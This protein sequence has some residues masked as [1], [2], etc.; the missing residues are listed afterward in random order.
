MEFQNALVV[1]QRMIGLDGED[2]VLGS[3]RVLGL[4]EKVTEIRVNN[5]VHADFTQNNITFEVSEIKCLW[6]TKI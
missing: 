3:V 5:T 6:L 4:V 2:M 1:S